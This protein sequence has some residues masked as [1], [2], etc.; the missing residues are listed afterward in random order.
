MRRREVGASDGDASRVSLSTNAER[1]R[2]ESSIEF[3]LRV[4]LL[5]RFWPSL[6]VGI[7]AESNHGA[8]LTE[9]Q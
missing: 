7:L 2:K 1:T 4:S 3:P 8:E 9:Y 5:L 6:E